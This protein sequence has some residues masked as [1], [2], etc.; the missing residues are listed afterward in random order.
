MPEIQCYKALAGQLPPDTEVIV[1]HEPN[2]W[3]SKIKLFT[4]YFQHTFKIPRNYK[5]HRKYMAMLQFALKHAKEGLE[6]PNFEE[7]RKE[8]AILA[9]FFYIK[10]GLSGKETKVAKSISFASMDDAEFE[11]L[12]SRSI[13]IIILYVLP[14]GTDRNEFE[15]AL[16]EVLGFC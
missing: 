8:I 12:Y 16:N 4:E 5:F 1:P 15:G 13:D 11:E 6:Y 7:F 10:R 9:G 2:K 3:L 14:Q